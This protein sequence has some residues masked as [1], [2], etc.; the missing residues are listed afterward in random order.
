ML[1]ILILDL[2]DDKLEYFKHNGIRSDR[3]V[4]IFRGV[5]EHLNSLTAGQR[6]VQ[7][8]VIHKIEE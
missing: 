7:W 4:I 8:K 3:E 2:D 1:K 5:E 6:R